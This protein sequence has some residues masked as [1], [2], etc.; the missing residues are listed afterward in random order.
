MGQ[1][2]VY[3]GQRCGSRILIRALD[4]LSISDPKTGTKKGGKVVVL[5][6]FVSTNITKLKIIFLTGKEKIE[7]IHRELYHKSCH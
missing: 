4:F 1:W 5:P 6:V 2:K 3:M 7:P